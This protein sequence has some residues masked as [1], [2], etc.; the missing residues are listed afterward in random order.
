MKGKVVGE[1]E[2]NEIQSKHFHIHEMSNGI[3]KIKG[4]E[5]DIILH[6]DKAIIGYTVHRPN[7]DHNDN[8]RVS[9]TIPEG[10]VIDPFPFG[11]GY[12]NTLKTQPVVMRFDKSQNMI[13]TF[14]EYSLSGECFPYWDVV[15]ALDKHKVRLSEVEE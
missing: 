8:R 9:I 4:K 3:L 11:T 10:G 5:F 7:H 1:F 14:S 12:D 6:P 13:L 15:K 2:S